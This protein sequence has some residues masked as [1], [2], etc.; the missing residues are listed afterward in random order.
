MKISNK[1]KSAL[2]TAGY[3]VASGSAI[4]QLAAFAAQPP[5]LERGN[6]GFDANGRKAFAEESR[7]IAG[8]WRRFKRALIDAGAVGVTDADVIAAAPDAF[9]GR[10]KWVAGGWEYCTGQ[11]FQTEYRKAAAAVLEYAARTIRRNREPK[12]RW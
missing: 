3:G 8:D 10:L 4:A 2:A 11:Y 1:A 5:A 12:G 9:S 7:K 6:Y